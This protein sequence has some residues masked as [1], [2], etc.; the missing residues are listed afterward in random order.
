MG[1]HSNVGVD[2]IPTKKKYDEALKGDAD[3]HEK[4]F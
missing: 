1:N 2:K 4:V 3:F